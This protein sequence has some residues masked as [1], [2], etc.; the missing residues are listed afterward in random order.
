MMESSQEESVS[1]VK[2]QQLSTE[3]H[4]L[5]IELEE[6]R[7]LL[8]LMKQERNMIELQASE[9]ARIKDEIIKELQG[10][11]RE[12]QSRIKI[13]EGRITEQDKIINRVASIHQLKEGSE[14]K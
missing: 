5:R 11:E 6:S 14:D 12:L 7:G 3:R 8:E 9:E 1:F 4:L 10:K 13:M 2:L